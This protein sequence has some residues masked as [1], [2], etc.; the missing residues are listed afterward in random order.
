[1]VKNK[2]I[3]LFGYGSFGRQIYK[4]LSLLG[5]NIRVISP[6]EKEISLADIEAV[7]LTKINIKKNDDILALNIDEKNSIFYCAMDR[8]AN[9]LFL[10]LTLKSLFPS[11]NVIAISNSNET[12]RKLKYAGASSVID[13]YEATSRRVVNSLTKPAVSRA[14]DEIVYKQ[15]DLN[16]LEIELP[17]NTFLEGKYVNE[18]NFRKIGIILIAIIDKELGYELV[19]TDHRINHKLDCGDTLVIVAKKENIAKFQDMLVSK[20]SV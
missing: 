10:V 5:H 4:N 1:M 14:L 7:S 20:H 18:I 15:N 9:N 11:A 3:V 12:T 16:M 2:N 13:L 17:A 6:M 8:T 19:F